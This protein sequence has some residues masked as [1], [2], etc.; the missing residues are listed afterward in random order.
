MWLSFSYCSWM[1]VC[2]TLS[3][4]FIYVKLIFYCNREKIYI[5]KLVQYLLK[6][7]YLLTFSS[8]YCICHNRVIII[9][10]IITDDMKWDRA[11]G[12]D[13]ECWNTCVPCVY[14]LVQLQL[15][16]LKEC[17]TWIC[18]GKGAYMLLLL[19]QCCGIRDIFVRIRGSV[20]LTKGSGFGSDSGSC[21]FRQWPSRW[22]LKSFFPLRFL[23][24][25]FLKLHVHHFS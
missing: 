4:W 16:W 12:A 2:F 25:Y 1:F 22:Q 24:D 8:L 11:E 5:A 7:D 21:F 19:L 14:L 18:R 9:I 3:T 15:A 6:V 20:P 23:A 17:G 13:W 10:I